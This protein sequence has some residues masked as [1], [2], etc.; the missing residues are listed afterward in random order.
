VGQIE[1]RRQFPRLR[2]RDKNPPGDLAMM[3]SA[4][5]LTLRR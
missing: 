4:Q 5:S 1:D 3:E 2:L